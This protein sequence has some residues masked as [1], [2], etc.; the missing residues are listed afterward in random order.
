MHPLRRSQIITTFGPG[1]LVVSKDEVGLIG[2][3]LDYWYQS[4]KRVD[5]REFIIDDDQR[6]ARRCNVRHFME[7]PD[8]RDSYKIRRYNIDYQN[9]DITLPYLRFPLWAYCNNNQCGKMHRTR[10]HTKE[11]YIKCLECDKGYLHQV[12]LISMCAD[13]H[14]DDFPFEEWIHQRC[15]QTDHNFRPESHSKFTFR[16][17]GGTGVAGYSIECTCGARRSL[18]GALNELDIECRGKRFWN[19]DYKDA[20]NCANNQNLYGSLRAAKNIYFSDVWTSIFIPERGVTN[21]NVDIVDLFNDPNVRPTIAELHSQAK[22]N[23]IT[24]NAKTLKASLSLGI[25]F[26]KFKDED[27]EKVIEYEY[28]PKDIDEEGDDQNNQANTDYHA[29]QFKYE[30]YD[31]ILNNDKGIR[32]FLAK[33]EVLEN[34]FIF[35]KPVTDYFDIIKVIKKLRETRVLVGFTRLFP[36]NLD[37]GEARR[38]LWRDETNT[39]NWLPG[40]KVYGEGI[41]LKFNE[42]ELKKWEKDN[43][44]RSRISKMANNYR[45]AREEIDNDRRPDQ[46]NEVITRNI[47]PRYVLIH[48]FSHLLINKLVNKSG[49]SAAAIKERI[50]SSTVD[51][52]MSGLLI[53][54]SDGDSEGTMG[55]LA[56]LGKIHNLTTVIEEALEE[57]G[58]CSIDPVCME[59]GNEDKGGQGPLSVNLAACHNCALVPETSCEN[60]NRFL[61]RGIVCGTIQKPDLG[62]FDTIK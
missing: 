20:T 41:F 24:I 54:T 46:M 39:D 18:S 35:N 31:F 34:H 13:G 3:G 62:Y 32:D 50:Y 58:W 57:A 5:T 28:P 30:E 14:I 40:V 33:K 12:P 15:R 44:V 45:N 21:L 4:D 7:P 60:F 23:N 49:Y 61:D 37:I 1:A 16:L 26:K 48:T 43:N 29:P 59:Q 56:R 9:L 51:P 19:C 36:R 27:I 6:L 17:T 42:S 52:D 25:D 8:Y 53:Y 10:P 38:L 22:Q 11:R 2:A 55:G 47:N